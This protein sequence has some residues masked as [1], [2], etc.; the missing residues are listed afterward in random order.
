MGVGRSYISRVVTV[1]KDSGA[2]TV[3]PGL[4]TIADRPRLDGRACACNE[5]VRAHFDKVLRNVYP[6]DGG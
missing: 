6:P 1:L 4:V 5:A 3:S 2:I